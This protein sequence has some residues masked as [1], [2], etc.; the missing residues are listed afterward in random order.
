MLYSSGTTGRPKGI[1]HQ[2]TGAPVGSADRL[3]LSNQ[4]GYGVTQDSVYLSPAPLYHSAPL[5]FCMAMH[6]LGATVVVMEHFDPVEMLRLIERYRVTHVQ[7]VPTM[8]V[9]LL[10]LP[11]DSGPATTSPAC[12]ASSTPP[13]LPGPGQA[14]DDRVVGSRSCRSTTPAP[15]ATASSPAHRRSG[16]PIPARSA[17]PRRHR[18]HRGRGRRRAA[19]RSSRARSTS[20]AARASSTT[21]TR[22][23][24]RRP[25]TTRGGRRSATSATSTTRATCTSPTARPT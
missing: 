15:R 13:P 21:T 17:R 10:K 22:T 25:A 8:F 16:W 3:A 4:Y 12:S 20:R 23:R 7:M 5:R 19:H 14:A 9:R 24:P 1:V 18:P 11:E 2:L 6:R